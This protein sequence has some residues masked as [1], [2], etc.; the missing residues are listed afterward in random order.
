[1]DMAQLE[2][3]GLKEKEAKVY[4]ALL[5]EGSSLANHISKKTNILRS[6]IYDYLDVLLDKGFI[7]YTIKA[8]KKYFQAVSPNKI[9]DSFQEKKKREEEDLKN[10]IPELAKLQDIGGKKSNIEIHEGKEGMKSVFSYILRDNPKEI[11]IYGSSGVGYKLLPYYLE[12][13]HKQRIKQKINIKIIYNKTK[14]SK[15]R[16]KKGPSLDLAEIRFLSVEHT[17]LTG[18]II[19]DNKVILTVWNIE[20]PLAIVIENKDIAENYADNFKI[21]WKTATP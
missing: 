14:E 11:L 18:T 20:S 17:S 19:Y 15:E 13:W 10:I 3:I 6:S 8:G 4:V 21:L 1:M 5:K 9:L 2:K 7:S 12:H 16:I